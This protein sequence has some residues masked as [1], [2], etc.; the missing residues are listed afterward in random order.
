M[1]RLFVIATLAALLVGA[2]TTVFAANDR[3]VSAEFSPLAASGISGRAALTEN[4]AGRTNVVLQ[5][6]GLEPETEY[7]SEWFASASCA[8]GVPQSLGTFRANP[9]GIAVLNTKVSADVSQIG[10]ISVKLGS[11]MS[12]QAC[13]TIPQ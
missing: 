11:D 4:G 3:H 12:L 6:K 7:V 13:A 5:L 8:E 9:A 2:G 1:R 10:S